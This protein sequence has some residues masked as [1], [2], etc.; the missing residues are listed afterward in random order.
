MKYRWFQATTLHYYTNV[1]VK[2]RTQ[3]TALIPGLVARLFLFWWLIFAASS[4]LAVVYLICNR[5][6]L[7]WVEINKVAFLTTNHCQADDKA[8]EEL[9]NRIRTS[10]P[11]DADIQVLHWRILVD[12]SLPA[13]DWASRMFPTH[14][15]VKEYNN[16]HL[17]LLTSSPLVTMQPQHKL[18]HEWTDSAIKINWWF[19]HTQRTIVSL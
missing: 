5:H 19:W 18:P 2:L 15:Q 8:R 16:Q 6:V 17:A 3:V 12:T 9:L 7:A 13:F 10:Q 4:F 14:K 11:T 1:G